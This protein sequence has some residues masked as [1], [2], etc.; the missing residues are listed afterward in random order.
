MKSENVTF[1]EIK[2]FQTS[3]IVS[4]TLLSSADAIIYN[5][6]AMKQIHKLA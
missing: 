2:L 4:A 1:L 5:N 6:T 3:I